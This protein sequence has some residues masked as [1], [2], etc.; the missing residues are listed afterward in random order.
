ME[1]LSQGDISQIIKE[2]NQDS[3]KTRRAYSKRRHDIY[4]DGG[5]KFLIEQIRRE[6]DS[7][8]VNEMRLAP[9]NILKKIINVQSTLYSGGVIRS[10]AFD[11]ETNQGLIDYYVKELKLD[12]KFQKA[13]RY[14]NLS[15]NVVMY[16]LPDGDKLKACVVPSYLYSIVPKALEPTEIQTYIF[17]QFVESS[18]IT[19][20]NDLNSATGSQGFSRDVGYKT[21]GDLVA[22]EE[23]DATSRNRYIFWS[24][25]EHFTTDQNGSKFKFDQSSG[26]E[27][28]INPIGRMP[29]INIAKDRDAEPWAQ[30]GEDLVDIALQF[31]LG[32]SD[33]MTTS[34]MQGFG[35]LTIISP[36]EPT[37]LTLGLNKAVWLKQQE[38]QQ[39][40]SISYVSSNSKISEIKDALMDML[41]LILTTNNLSPG[42]VSGMMQAK[43]F[44]SGFQALIESSDLLKSI[45]E[46]KPVMRDAEKEFWKVLSL[47]H[48]YMFDIGVLNND[49]KSLGKFSEDFELSV[50]YKDV[51]QLES[52]QERISAVTSLIS[53]GLM[54]R[55]DAL[56]KL[57]PDLTDD[58]VTEKLQAIDA[59]KKQR[60]VD[61]EAIFGSN[62]IQ[63]GL[64]NGEETSSKETS[65]K[66]TNGKES[67]VNITPKTDQANG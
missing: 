8:A 41:G 59:E 17:N 66:E 42:S 64:Q 55:Q 28:Y 51:K 2:I 22:S 23:K 3:E 34:K 6:F 7:K 20:N 44:T 15:S 31:Q 19:P 10:S 52:E 14:Y 26:D 24:D 57:N 12:Q 37:N 25:N 9:I 56:K 62:S 33:I 39:T 18:Q 54:T 21:N 30:Q 4:V 53:L 60:Q 40:P 49:A 46:Q 47:W 36:E 13:N 61:A 38:G 11:N 45:E 63:G 65:S 5:R 1:V 43:N 67:Q 29:V 27:Q 48:N 32:W 50:L 58:Q 16:V 35:I